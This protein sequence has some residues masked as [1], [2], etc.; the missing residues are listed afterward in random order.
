MTPADDTLPVRFLREPLQPSG[1][2]LSE[3]ELQRMIAEYYTL[4]GW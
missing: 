1:E 2:T 4:R 3:A